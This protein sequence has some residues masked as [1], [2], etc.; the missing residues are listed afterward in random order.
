MKITKS[1][2]KQIIKEELGQAM[3]RPHGTATLQPNSKVPVTIMAD[4]TFN[5]D[6]V[7]EGQSFAITGTIDPGTLEQLKEAGVLG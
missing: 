1:Q 4:G 6:V 5:M 7:V 3:A 2:L